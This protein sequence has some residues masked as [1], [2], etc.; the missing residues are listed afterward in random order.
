MHGL[1]WPSQRR[2]R[3]FRT[4]DR[5]GLHNA[6]QLVKKVAQKL[7]FQSMDGLTSTSCASF[8][9]DAGEGVIAVDRRHVY[10]YC[11]HPLSESSRY[12]YPW[13]TLGSNTIHMLF[14]LQLSESITQA[15]QSMQK[16][17]RVVI[18]HVASSIKHLTDR[19]GDGTDMYV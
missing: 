11:S 14:A 19:L 10:P 2:E 7:L 18:P 8:V 9:L 6:S 16:A 12:H 17:K 3:G 4:D 1:A 13:H 5:S 15:P